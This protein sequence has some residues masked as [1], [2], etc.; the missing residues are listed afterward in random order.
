MA[1]GPIEKE[2]LEAHVELYQQRYEVLERRLGNVESR[3]STYMM[4]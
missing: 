3:F 1:T 2:N 4:T